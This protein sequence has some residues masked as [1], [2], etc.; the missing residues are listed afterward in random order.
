MS[1]TTQELKAEIEKT[2]GLMRTLRDEVRVKVHLADMDAKRAWNKLEP[3][4]SEVERTASDFGEATRTAAS[5][6]VK[7]LTELRSSLP[8]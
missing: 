4:L 5:E 7:R 1:Q 3:Y 2:L 6:A 8:R